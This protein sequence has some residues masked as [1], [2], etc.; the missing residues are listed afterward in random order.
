MDRNEIRKLIQQEIARVSEDALFDKP[1][2]GE[3]YYASVEDEYSEDSM[4]E[5]EPL[6]SMIPDMDAERDPAYKLSCDSCGDPMVMQDGC[7]CGSSEKAWDTFDSN[8]LSPAPM[9]GPFE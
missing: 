8:M 6:P 5:V 4:P 1:K 9:V 2:V 7:G 3:P